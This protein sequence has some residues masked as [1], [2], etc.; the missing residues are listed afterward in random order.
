MARPDI[1][2]LR[3]GL[4]ERALAVC[5][6]YLSNGR[7]CGNYWTVGDL[8]NRPGRS[9]F[10]RLQTEGA[11]RRAGRWTD[12]ATGEYGDLL[13]IIQAA[14][15]SGAFKDALT[16]AAGFLGQT[17]ARRTVRF[18]AD[19]PRRRT[20][21]HSAM[22][23][24]LFAQSTSL[25][26]TLGETYLIGRGI[27]PDVATALRYHAQCYCRPCVIDEPSTRPAL[28]APV[29]DDAGTLTG[30][31][32]I[33][34]DRVGLAAGHLGKAPIENPKRSLGQI[35]GHVVRFGSPSHEIVVAEGIENALSIRTAFPDLT[36]HA[37]LTAGNLAAYHWAS[38]L[39]RLLIA[40]DDDEAGLSAAHTLA[41]R[42]GLSGLSATLL[43]PRTA[44]HNLDL[45]IFGQDAYRQWLLAQM[46]G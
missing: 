37:A 19:R 42:A 40:L 17:P 31:H 3:F 2:D 34:L 44:D 12:A 46:A 20:V 27:A 35:Q 10:V 30:V 9:L 45:R 23:R 18:Q 24:D 22:A 39:R 38:A 8:Q 15:H 36:V 21:H 29:T 16:E 1:D 33:Y 5:R 13:D 6:H 4:A 25:A 32:R 41:E 7:R 26:H 43:W 28:I 11:G 14:T